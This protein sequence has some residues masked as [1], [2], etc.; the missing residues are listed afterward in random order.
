MTDEEWMAANPGVG[1]CDAPG[2]YTGD[3]IE[4]LEDEIKRLNER[5]TQGEQIVSEGIMLT[6]AKDAEIAHLREIEEAARKYR[7]IVRL[8]INSLILIV[9]RS[10]DTFAFADLHNDA[11]YRLDA[12]LGEGETK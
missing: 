7:E 6:D 8:G 2:T 4:E 11:G 10:S 3:R 9:E 5:L 1:S 12:L